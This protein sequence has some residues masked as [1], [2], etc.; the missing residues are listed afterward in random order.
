MA[1][2]I[3]DESNLSSTKWWEARRLRYN[4]GMVVA[5]GFAFLLYI[6]V[7]SVIGSFKESFTTQRRIKSGSEGFEV[8]GRGE[9]GDAE[10]RERARK[11]G[12][13]D[14]GAERP[15]RRARQEVRLARHH[16][17]RGDGGEGDR[18]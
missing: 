10:G 13:R 17:R 18:A 1:A 16:Q 6:L 8:Q 7:Q 11:R 15:E 5:G 3:Q 14:A 9:G 4:V 2:G 12:A